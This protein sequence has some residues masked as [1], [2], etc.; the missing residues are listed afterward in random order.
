MFTKGFSFK[1]KD[2]DILYIVDQIRYTKKGVKEVH[3]M[4]SD[5]K[6]MGWYIPN[7]NKTNINIITMGKT[8]FPEW[9]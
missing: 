2:E 7:W 3:L 6:D 5:N 8:H 1:F 9:F 4:R